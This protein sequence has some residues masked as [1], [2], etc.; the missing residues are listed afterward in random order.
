MPAFS[1]DAEII[2]CEGRW[3]TPGLIDCHTHLVFGGNRADEHALRRAGAEDADMLIACAA[4][5]EPLTTR[6]RSSAC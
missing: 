6:V 2:D 5:A 4:H 1:G 3:I